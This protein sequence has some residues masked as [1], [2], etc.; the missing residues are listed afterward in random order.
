MAVD[1]L[2]CGPGKEQ[3][4]ESQGNKARAIEGQIRQGDVLLWA[5]GTPL[6]AGAE[7]QQRDSR[8]RIV[9]EY[10][11][12]TGHAHAVLDRGADLYLDSTG[13]QH[14]VVTAPDVP[15]VHEE[16]ETVLLAMAVYHRC[17]QFEYDEGEERR[18]AD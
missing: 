1:G 12:A 2:R 16:H 6:P 17:P 15:L 9:L 18:V 4:V 10:G 14:L 11:E 7:L 8:G 3:S 5:D 13:R